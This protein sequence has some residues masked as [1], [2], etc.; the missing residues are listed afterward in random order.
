MKTDIF[1]LCDSAQD[2]NGKLII[3]GTFNKIIVNQIP[4]MHPEFAVVARIIFDEN[5]KREHNIEFC[6][7][8]DD[9]VF[10]M[11]THK[12]KVDT[13]NYDGK[14]ASINMI[15]K[16]NN[17]NIPELGAYSIILKVDEQYWKSSLEVSLQEQT[18]N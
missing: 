6:I 7:K 5:E 12:M 4:A 14:E 15:V 18:F 9:N 13:S 3:I 1:T 10:I 11:P 17:I 2:Y 16:G 8:N